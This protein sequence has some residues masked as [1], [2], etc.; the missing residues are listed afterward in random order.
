MTKALKARILRN[1]P[2][3]DRKLLAESDKLTRELRKLGNTMRPTLRLVPP[4]ERRRVSTTRAERIALAS[5]L[6]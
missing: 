2:Q 6:S 4:F 3:V 5:K 1:N